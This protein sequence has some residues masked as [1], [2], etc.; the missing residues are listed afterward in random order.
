MINRRFMTVPPASLS[1]GCAE[2]LGGQA[3]K[4]RACSLKW[5]TSEL[6]TC[7]VDGRV[8]HSHAASLGSIAK[9]PSPAHRIAFWTKLH[10][11]QSPD[12]QLQRESA[13]VLETSIVIVQAFRC[14]LICRP[15]AQATSDGLP[16]LSALSASPCQCANFVHQHDIYCPTLQ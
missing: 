2:Q 9:P 5:R 4:I 14:S 11:L 1:G 13:T 6:E 7:R 8:R 16:P 10:H 12:K 3:R 15:Y